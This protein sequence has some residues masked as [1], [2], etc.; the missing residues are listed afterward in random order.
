[1]SRLLIVIAIIVALGGCGSSHDSTP[2][3]KKPPVSAEEPNARVFHVQVDG[4][5][6]PCIM[7]DPPKP[8]VAMTCDWGSR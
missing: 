3:P 8:M 6:I 4:R 1:M 5:S 7:V 2:K